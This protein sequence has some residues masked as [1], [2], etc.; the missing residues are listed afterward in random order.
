MKFIFIPHYNPLRKTTELPPS[1]TAEFGCFILGE[2]QSRK[3]K[4]SYWVMNIKVF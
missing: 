3:T 4:K 1:Q 2:I